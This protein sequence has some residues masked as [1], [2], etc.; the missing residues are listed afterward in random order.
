MSIDEQLYD[1]YL[2]KCSESMRLTT[3]LR[4]ARPGDKDALAKF[5]ETVEP[6]ILE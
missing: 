1:R 3:E 6:V 2:A 5:N 4:S